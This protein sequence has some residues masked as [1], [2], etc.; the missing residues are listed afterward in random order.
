MTHAVQTDLGPE[1]RL[2]G[3]FLLIAFIA[4]FVGVVTGLFQ[5][6][7]HIGVNVYPWLRP[8]VQSYY[9]GLSLHGVMNVLVW[10]TFFICGFVP[11]IAA[12]AYNRPLSSR[13]LGWVTFG[14]MVVGLL[15]AGVPLLQNN[16]TV[17]FTFLCGLDIGGGG[18]LAGDAESAPHPTRLASRASQRANAASGSD[19]PYHFYYV[20]YRL[21][22]IGG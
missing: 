17:M 2:T 5:G 4:L 1:R 20:E 19:V 21:H 16:A 7:S 22:R 9:H 15:I 3:A 10:T 6:L 18:H 11:F 8:L 14:L 13:P 12:R